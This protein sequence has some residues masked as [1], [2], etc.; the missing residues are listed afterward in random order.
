M[1]S[2]EY[3]FAPT[4]RSRPHLGSNLEIQDLM[5]DLTKLMKINSRG[6]VCS[7]G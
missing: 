4:G 2:L 6:S 5:L 7:M 1:I 3:V